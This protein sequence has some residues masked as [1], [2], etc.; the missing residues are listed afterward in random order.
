VGVAVW[1]VEICNYLRSAFAASEGNCGGTHSRSALYLLGPGVSR[2]IVFG[3]WGDFSAGG[4]V[5]LQT[6]KYSHPYGLSDGVFGGGQT[7]RV[8]IRRGGNPE[9]FAPLSSVRRRLRRRADDKGA[10]TEGRQRLGCRWVD[11]RLFSRAIAK[12]AD[13]EGN[14]VWPARVI[15]KRFDQRRICCTGCA[16][17]GWVEMKTSEYS[18]RKSLSAGVFGGGQTLAGRIRRGGGGL[19]AFVRVVRGWRMLRV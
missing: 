9:V 18:R 13:V 14:C 8:R 7:I 19:N 1:G 5:E 16:G 12:T 11:V 10:N 4:G 17:G 6:P 3:G 2:G 15:L